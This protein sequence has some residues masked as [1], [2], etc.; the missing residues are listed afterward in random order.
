M[1]QYQSTKSEANKQLVFINFQ[2]FIYKKIMF[3][4]KTDLNHLVIDLF[5]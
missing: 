3:T 1:D 2:G 4:S 5:T